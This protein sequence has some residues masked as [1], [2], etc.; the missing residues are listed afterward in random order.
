MGV[1]VGDFGK[2]GVLW[3]VFCGEVCGGMRGKAGSLTGLKWD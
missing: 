3:M 1:F 2:M